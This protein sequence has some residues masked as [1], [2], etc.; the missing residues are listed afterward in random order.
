MSSSTKPNEKIPS[1]MTTGQYV[2]I[3]E[4]NGKECE[5][6]YYFI[7]YD[8]NE[9]VLQKLHQDIESIEWYII[10]DLSTFDVELEHKVSALT[11]KEMTKVE[12]NCQS[13]HR[14]F[15]GKLKEI[16]FAFKKKDSNDKKI[17]RVF[18]I[19]GYGQIDEHFE[20]NDPDE[21]ID[22]EDLISIHSSDTD[23]SNSSS[24]SSS[25]DDDD[26]DDDKKLDNDNL[27][28]NL[29]NLEL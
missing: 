14:K 29:K 10:D 11:A 3:Q 28:D 2:I 1:R 7:R 16:N 21:D 15:D 25:S 19:L 6:W 17:S 22:E 20:N 12:L 8:G 4:T 26:D 9:Q 24:S 13:F 23:D 18:D 27:P 5:S